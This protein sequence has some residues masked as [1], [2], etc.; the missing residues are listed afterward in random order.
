MTMNPFRKRQSGVAAVEFAL[1]SVVFFTLLFGAIEMARMLFY[2]NT[3][4]EA[5][6][7]GAR[8][9][10]VCDKDDGDIKGQMTALFPVLG[11]DDISIDYLPS[12]CTAA[13]CQQVTVR[14]QKASAID[15]YIPFLPLS[16]TM[17]SFLTTLSRESMSSSFNGT[18]N[19]ICG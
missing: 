5:T 13:N 17:P 14:V 2:W 15:T 18:A 16:L 12:G 8:I 6:R 1:V 10:V 9:A 7:Y 11:A 19:P 4:T 3:A